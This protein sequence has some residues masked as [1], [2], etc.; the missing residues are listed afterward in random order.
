MNKT[1]NDRLREWLA[2][3]DK[4]LKMTTADSLKTDET[5]NIIFRNINGHPGLWEA[6]KTIEKKGIRLFFMMNGDCCVVSILVKKQARLS[7]STLKA[8]TKR[9]C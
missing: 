4:R 6:R 1:G 2:S 9:K 5:A 3:V 8:F 7:S